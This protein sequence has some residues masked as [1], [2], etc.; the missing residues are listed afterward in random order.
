M[1]INIIVVTRDEITY[2]YIGTQKISSI[3]KESRQRNFPSNAILNVS[4]FL[5]SDYGK[6][7]ELNEYIV[8]LK[9]TS[10][11]VIMIYEQRLQKD[12]RRY[13]DCLFTTSYGPQGRMN[14]HN[15]MNMT[16]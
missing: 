7:T 11:F 10:D 4:Y 8:R 5:Y 12:L 6:L 13:S 2:E 9:H 14:T 3:P 15:Q 1:K 16:L